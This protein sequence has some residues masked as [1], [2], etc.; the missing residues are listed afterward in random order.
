MNKGRNHSISREL[1]VFISVTFLILL[2]FALSIT[3]FRVERRMIDEYRRMADGVTNLMIEA[4]DP[5]RMDDYIEENY[6]SPGYREIMRF[7]YQLKDNYPDVYYLYV[8]RFYK[9]GDA[10][11]G[12]I[13]IDLEEEY[14]DHPNQ[15]SIDWVGGTYDVLEPF[16]SRQG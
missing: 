10:A 8:Y 6:S 16:A 9:E 11:Y 3:F 15:A 14:T 7:F 12:T 13:I 4:L 1:P 2:A 5:D